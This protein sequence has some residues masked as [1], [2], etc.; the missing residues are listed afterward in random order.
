MNGENHHI[1]PK[2]IRPDL[3][4]DKDNIVRLTYREH[5]IAHLCLYRLYEDDNENRYKM[6]S[7]WLR[8]CNNTNGQHVSSHEFELAK[9]V[10]YK[11]RKG[12]LFHKGHILS[13]EQ[14][15]LVSQRT[16]AAM[17]RPDVMIRN[18]ERVK[19]HKQRMHN[20]LF[21]NNGKTCIRAKECPGEGW[22]RGKLT[23]GVIWW[24]NG[25]LEKWSKESPGP[26]WIKGRLYKKNLKIA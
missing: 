24:N 23:C 18:K 1:I 7:A 9:I 12:N 5:Y 6:A 8:M 3:V 2:S 11:N 26:E 13:K 17:L 25:S 21:W 10:A 4:K 22:V 15:E 19:Q 14:R 20:S 16:K